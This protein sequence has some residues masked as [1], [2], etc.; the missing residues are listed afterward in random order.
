MF[1]NDVRDMHDMV[2]SDVR[3]SEQ[4]GVTI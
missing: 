2:E 4:F 1:R 3:F